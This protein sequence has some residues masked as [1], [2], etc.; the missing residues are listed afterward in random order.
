MI[1]LPEQFSGLASRNRPLDENVGKHLAQW[2]AGETPPKMKDEPRA[3]AANDST[4]GAI[5]DEPTE[6]EESEPAAEPAETAAWQPFVDGVSARIEA[7]TTAEALD[8]ISED[9]GAAD[10]V[11]EDE[12]AKLDAAVSK[13]RRGLK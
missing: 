13:K 5:D 10:H 12:I 9:I 7:A 4:I 8:E 11:P 1:K 3:F 2:A 6:A